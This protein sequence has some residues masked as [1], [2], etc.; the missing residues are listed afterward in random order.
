MARRRPLTARSLLVASGAMVLACG[1]AK[2]AIGGGEGPIVTGNL[3]PPPMVALCVEAT[4]ST[5][6]VLVNAREPDDRG[7]VDTYNGTA[8]VT[9]TAEGYVPYEEKVD[10]P[11]SDS[12]KMHAI[13]MQPVPPPTP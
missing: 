11:M 13:V 3:M 2:T 5:A 1:G 9:A 8:T 7:C 12:P 10:L 6:K 4:P